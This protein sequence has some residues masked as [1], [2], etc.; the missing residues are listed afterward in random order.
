MAVEGN[1]TIR[2]EVCGDVQAEVISL[3]GGIYS[4]GR[5]HRCRSGGV[6]PP[7]SELVPVAAQ[8][9]VPCECGRMPRK[10]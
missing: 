3:H 4:E 1:R 8:Y 5:G 9:L 7:Q 6:T 10:N 2:Q